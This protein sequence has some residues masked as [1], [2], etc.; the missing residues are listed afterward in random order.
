[1]L[2]SFLLQ[3]WNYLDSLNISS[4]EVLVSSKFFFKIGDMTAVEGAA[5]RS[6]RRPLLWFCIRITYCSSSFYFS[7]ALASF[8]LFTEACSLVSSSDISFPATAEP[9]TAWIYLIISVL[10]ICFKACTFEC[11]PILCYMTRAFWSW[12]SFLNWSASLLSLSF[13][14][15]MRSFSLMIQLNTKIQRV[16]SSSDAANKSKMRC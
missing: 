13:R 8:I 5:V 15:A 11:E 6:I 4:M 10:S 14:S 1:M 2:F 7:R 3:A 9:V 12:L 16:R